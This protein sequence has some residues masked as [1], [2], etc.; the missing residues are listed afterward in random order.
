M[1]INEKVRRLDLEREVLEKKLDEALEGH[2]SEEMGKLYED[3]IRNFEINTILRG[4]IVNL[5]NDEVVVDVGYKSEGIISAQEFENIEDFSIGDDVEVFLEAV[6]DEGGSIVLSRKKAER[7]RGWER[8][9]STHKEGDTVKGQVIRKIKGGLLVNIGVPVFLPASQIGIRRTGDIAEYIG[10]ELECKIIKIDEDRMNIVVSRRR[11]LEE[12]REE[13]KRKL[14]AEIEE[15]QVR[16]GIVKNIADFGAFVDLGGIDGLLHITDMSWGR[17]SHPSELLAIDDKI[18]IKVLRVDKER[19]RIALGLKQLSENPWNDVDSKYPIGSKVKGKVVNIMS[20]GAFIKL[21]SGVEGLVHISEMSWTK[22]INHPSEMVAI[23]DTVEVVIL[24]INKEKQEISLG[25]KQVEVNPWTQVEEKYPSGTVISGRVRNLTN[26]GAFI[27]IEEG[28]D[29]LL[30]ISDMS[31]TKKVSHPSEVLKKG[32]KVTAV[33]LSVDQEKKRVALGLKQLTED[34]WRS[35]IPEKYKVGDLVS[36]TVTKITNFG[37][38]VELEEN[39]EGLLHISELSD[40]KV[41]SPNEVVSMSQTLEVSIIKV[42][43]E[44]RKIGLSMIKGFEK[45]GEEVAKK[46][47]RKKEKKAEEKEPAPVEAASKDTY[48]SLSELPPSLK[49]KEAGEEKKAPERETAPDLGEG[50]GEAPPSTAE[51]PVE[52]KEETFQEKEVLPSDPCERDAQGGKEASPEASEPGAEPSPRTEEAPSA[53][54]KEKRDLGE[55]PQVPKEEAP[56]GEPGELAG[57]EKDQAASEERSPAAG[58][59]PGAAESEPPSLMESF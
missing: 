10:Q 15:G 33:V 56:F 32:E 46:K 37:V 57:H 31:W 16:T 5:T 38:F 4:K 24:D 43:P 55:E 39:L 1:S 49:K 9:V 12:K 50:E 28:I 51:E 48:S 29:G 42:D 47:P 36:G 40:K 17:I 30:H 18:D 6:E 3:S 7:I 19:E 59:T 35:T 23:G 53:P 20:Y 22:R 11:L 21:E 26:Y 45:E 14:L 41:K 58:G 13:M 52:M 25:M 44:E 8:I 2:K 34:P 27:E 54:E